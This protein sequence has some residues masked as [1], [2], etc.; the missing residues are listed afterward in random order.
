MCYMYLS[1]MLI[2]LMHSYCPNNYVNT[3][4]RYDE[5]DKV[6]MVG[7]AMFDITVSEVRIWCGE[8]ATI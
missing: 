6:S 4:L 2:V 7:V 3:E 8:E 5:C 1:C